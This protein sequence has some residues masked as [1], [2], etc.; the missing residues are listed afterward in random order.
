MDI[1][2]GFLALKKCLNSAFICYNT[3]KLSGYIYLLIQPVQQQKWIFVCVN[4]AVLFR[5]VTK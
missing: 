5:L 1:N 3:S 2:F 4:M